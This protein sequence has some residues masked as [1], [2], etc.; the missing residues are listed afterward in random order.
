MKIIIHRTNQYVN[1]DRTIDIYCN[2]RKIGKVRNGETKEFE[3]ENGGNIIYAKI[4]WCQTKPLQIKST[5]KI[6]LA[7]GSNIIGWRLFFLLYYGFLNP[8]NYIYLIEKK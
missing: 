5:D 4:D 8:S 6:D 1:R 7:L 2:K 3:I